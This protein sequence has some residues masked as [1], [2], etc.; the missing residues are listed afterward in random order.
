M[1]KEIKITAFTDGEL[2]SVF[3]MVAAHIS[4]TRQHKDFT[5]PEPLLTNAKSFCRKVEEVLGDAEVT[6][7]YNELVLE[8]H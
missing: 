8:K 1:T 3:G 5:L 2:A 6:K 4:A 7:S